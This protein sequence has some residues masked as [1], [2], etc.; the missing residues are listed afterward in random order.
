[1]NEIYI[2]YAK[3]GHISGPYSAPVLLFRPAAASS[4]GNY[5]GHAYPQWLGT[6][7]KELIISWTYN[8]SET[9]MALVTFS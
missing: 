3:G 7:S 9:R 6:E 2:Q 4:F 1:M 8:S 5:A